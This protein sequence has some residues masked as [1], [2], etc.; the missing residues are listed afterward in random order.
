MN[1][2][3]QEFRV[4]SVK[5]CDSF[6]VFREMCAYHLE[7]NRAKFELHRELKQLRE[8][9]CGKSPCDVKVDEDFY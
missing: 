8:E 6:A 9:K 2:S 5:G 3:D 7:K 1:K 4:C